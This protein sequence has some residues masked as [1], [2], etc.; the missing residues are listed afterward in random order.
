MFLARNKIN[1]MHIHTT[2]KQYQYIKSKK[3]VELNIM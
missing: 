2:I 3:K 1:K